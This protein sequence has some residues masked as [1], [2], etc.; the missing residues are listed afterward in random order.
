MI[1]QLS[2]TENSYDT[3]FKEHPPFEII[4]D[5]AV[6]QVGNVL[7][8]KQTIDM[9]FQIATIGTQAMEVIPLMLADFEKGLG[10]IA[11]GLK[12]INAELD[13]VE[14]LLTRVEAAGN[15][16]LE[17][18]V[19][20]YAA[21]MAKVEA[22]ENSY[23][24]QLARLDADLKTTGY[25]QLGRDYA[26]RP[27]TRYAERLAGQ[28]AVQS[29][30]YYAAKDKT[31]GSTWSLTKWNKDEERSFA[32]EARLE[33]DAG[34]TIG[35]AAVNLSNRIVAAAYT[36]PMSDSASCVFHDVP[37]NDITNT[38]KVLIQRVNGRDVTA[39]A[40]AD[41]IKISPLEA[42]GYTKDGWNIAGYGKNGYDKYGYNKNGYDKDGYDKYGYDRYGYD[43]YGR[44]KMGLTQKEVEKAAQQARVD[45]R[46]AKIDGMWGN[47]Y[48]GP[49]YEGVFNIQPLGGLG[50]FGLEAGGKWL[51]VNGGFGFGGGSLKVDDEIIEKK[52]GPMDWNGVTYIFSPRVG[53]AFPL[54]FEKARLNIGG[55]LELLSIM[56]VEHVG[57][58]LDSNGKEID[59]NSA[60]RLDNLFIPYVEARLD[61]ALTQRGGLLGFIGY[62]CEFPPADQFETYFGEPS[63]LRHT[64]FAGFVVRPIQLFR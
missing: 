58:K 37:V 59:D 19:N 32:I 31:L 6:K 50:E 27:D 35:T 21:Q 28:Y 23:A 48:L 30:W 13:K 18:L 56:V 62:R 4:Y 52:L 16:A 49:F 39:A 43:R 51:I 10:T 24:A 42:D 47:F 33:N 34:K 64:I 11:Q 9:Q 15:N 2:E 26:V 41:Y 22:A 53:A 55:G 36:Q 25:A 14:S 29:A 57:K 61:F 17:R 20:D 38:L 60:R 12:D 44:N 1:A 8:E 46:Q 45:A 40:N 7:L 3:F 5:P 54:N 63:S